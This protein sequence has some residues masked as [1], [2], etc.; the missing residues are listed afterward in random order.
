MRLL[1][2]IPDVLDQS[3]VDRWYKTDDRDSFAYA[4]RLIA[5]EG[6]LVGGS[7]GSAFAAMVKANHDLKL[8]KEC[9][10][11]VILPDSIRNYLSKFVDDDWLAANDLLPPY[12]RDRVSSPR[13]S[14]IDRPP[15]S[16]FEDATVRDLGLKPV[17][18]I[19]SDSTCKQ[20][21]EIMQ[22]RGFDQLPVLGNTEPGRLVGL[23]TLGNLLSLI[24]Q[25]RVAL[26]ESVSN[27]MFDFS[28]IFEITTD[29]R[30]LATRFAS[31]E[32]TH[33]QANGHSQ[34]AGRRPKR[35]FIDI[36]MD[37]PLKMLNEFFEW[38]SAAVVIQRD[39]KGNVEPVAV[40]TKVDLLSWLAK[41]QIM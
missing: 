3:V 11:V 20:A 9:N 30:D 25:G 4:R 15:S 28:K 16:P 14:S 37:T 18:S 41:Q 38:N 8:G 31:H 29:A 26:H 5:E 33:G 12:L 39:A 35:K 17:E 13:R 23:V 21:I 6:L 32:K 36:T 40:A 10:I 2:F 7:S 34:R 27:A 22:E 19:R 1:D 24:G